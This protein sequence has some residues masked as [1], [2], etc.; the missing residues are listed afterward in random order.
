M[1]WIIFFDEATKKMVSWWIKHVIK[2]ATNN[3]FKTVWIWFFAT[4]ILQWSSAVLLILESFVSAGMMEFTHAARV[5]MWANIWSSAIGVILWSLWL[6]FD[7]AAYALPLLG[8]LAF[9]LLIIKS[10][11][12]KNI[13]KIVIWLCLIFVWLWYMNDW[14]AFVANAVDFVKLSSCSI[15]LFYFVGLFGTMIMQSSAITIALTLSAASV[16]LV[17]YR[18]WIMMLLWCFLWTT[19]T[20]VLWCIK[21]WY[22]KKQ[23][24][25]TQVIFNAVLSVFGIAL[26]P[27]FVWLMNKITS[28]VVLGLSIFTLLFKIVWVALML[29]FLNKFIALIQKRF[30]KKNPNF[31][32]NI[33]WVSPTVIPAWLH[34]LEQDLL[35]VLKKVLKHAL[36]T[37]NTREKDLNTKN[38]NVKNSLKYEK[39]RIILLLLMVLIYHFLKLFYLHFLQYFLIVR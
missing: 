24:A 16:W 15:A 29:P 13:L 34:A 2:K 25:A 14:M 26:L 4:I 38:Y 31:G 23:V 10:D 1:L 37:W 19:S 35:F 8:A 7:L 39:S 21:W 6:E 18:M 33:E 17:D 5:I 30:P 27:V 9:A 20:P 22:L 28:D 12:A 3:L 36:N 11:K 32:L